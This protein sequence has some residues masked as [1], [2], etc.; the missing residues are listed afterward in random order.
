MES[1]LDVAD[2][3]SR[4]VPLRP[5]QAPEEWLKPLLQHQSGS[6]REVE[7]RLQGTKFCL[8]LFAGRGGLTA[9]W[10]RVG[11]TVGNRMRRFPWASRMRPVLT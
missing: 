1:K 3:P 10:R 6:E 9:A 5:P 2:D 7:G 4:F 8:E 11:L